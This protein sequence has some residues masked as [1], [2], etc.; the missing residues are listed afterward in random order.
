MPPPRDNERRDGARVE[1]ARQAAQRRKTRRHKLKTR[2][3]ESEKAGAAL[4]LLSAALP[5]PG[6]TGKR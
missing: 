1:R 4:D 5:T 6:R 2:Q 3:R